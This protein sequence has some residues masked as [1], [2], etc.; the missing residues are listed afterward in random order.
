MTS[1]HDVPAQLTFPGTTT[2]PKYQSEFLRFMN[3]LLDVAREK[4]GEV[5]PGEIYDTV[6]DRVGLSEQ[7]RTAA[8]KN[9]TPR[10]KNQIAWARSFLVQ[11]GF[12]DSPAA[13]VWGLTEKGTGAHLDGPDIDAIY[14]KVQE[15]RA[16]A[17]AAS[18]AGTIVKDDEDE[19]V[20]PSAQASVHSNHKAILVQLIGK[21]THAGFEEF[22]AELLRH[23]KVDEVQTTVPVKDGGIDGYGRLRINTFVSLP[24]AFQ[25]KKY[26]G[27]GQK[28]SSEEIQK[29]RGAMGSHIA[30]GIFFTTTTFTDDARKEAK[31]PGKTEIELIDLDRIIEICEEYKIGLKKEEIFVPVQSF[32]ENVLFHK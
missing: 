29:F 26:D 23:A 5:R 3:P 17:K 25:A 4:G 10:F 11:T 20:A 19:T 22:C 18:T 7:A 30:K 32:F 13:G 8:L 2:P 31:A 9:G 6:A 24:I 1:E 27:S 12:M 28:I 21:M 14:L 16:L 15:L